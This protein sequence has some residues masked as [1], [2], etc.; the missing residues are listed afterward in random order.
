MKLSGHRHILA[1]HVFSL[2]A[3]ARQDINEQIGCRAALENGL[4][5]CTAQTPVTAVKGTLTGWRVEVDG[6]EGLRL[7]G[8]AADRVG[9]EAPLLHG[10]DRRLREDERAADDLQVLHSAIAANRRLQDHGAVQFLS[11]GFRRIGGIYAVDQQGPRRFL[12]HGYRLAELLR[13]EGWHRR[14]GDGHHLRWID[15]Y[16]HGRRHGSRTAQAIGNPTAWGFDRRWLLVEGRGQWEVRRIAQR[17]AR[18]GYVSFG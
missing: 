7:D 11:R 18:V 4:K 3:I 2:G 10:G 15:R 9:L 6:E 8:M 1:E 12:A 17:N 16:H 14:A 5:Q 13:G